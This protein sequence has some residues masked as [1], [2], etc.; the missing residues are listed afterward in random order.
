[1]YPCPCQI[2][3]CVL[4]EAKLFSGLSSAQVCEI[5]GMLGMHRYAPQEVLFRAG[6]PCTHL[7]ALRLGQVKLSTALPDGREQILGLR[8]GGQLVGLETVDDTV[9]PYTATALT[10]VVACRITHK[11]MLRVL[12]Q[13]PAVSLH[14]IQRINKD[15]E[16]ARALIRD[17]GIKTA[18]ERVA[19]FILSL[20]PVGTEPTEPLPFALSRKEIAELLGLTVETVSRVMAEFRRAGL[21]EAPRGGLRLLDVGRLQRLAGGEHDRNER[22]AGH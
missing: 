1:M 19:S 13:N 20:V 14:V 5:R 7:I 3:E 8:V 10:P 4:C 6:E 22:K 21:I 16:Q 2:E 12:Q 11:D 18:H 17:L 9:Y 15:L